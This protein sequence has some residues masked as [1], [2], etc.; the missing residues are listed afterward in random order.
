MLS[1]KIMNSYNLDEQAAYC[2]AEEGEELSQDG[3]HDG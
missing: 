3:I 1:N 2:N